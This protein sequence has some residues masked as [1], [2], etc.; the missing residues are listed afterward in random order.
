M[1]KKTGVGFL[2]GLVFVLLTAS[3]AFS[4]GYVGG[5]LGVS[6]PHDVSNLRGS[7]A[8]GSGGVSSFT[9]DSSVAGEFR[10]GYFF[11]SI[12]WLGAEFNFSISEPDVD[13][14]V[15]ITITSSPGGLL[16]GLSTGDFIGVVDVDHYSTMGF[17]LMLSSERANKTYNG[18]GAFGGLGF[19]VNVLDIHRVE[20]LNT[21]RVKQS[22]VD[23][24]SITDI[25]FLMSVGLDY[26]ITENVK[27]YGAYKYKNTDFT[28]KAFDDSL[29]YKFNVEE[30]ALTFGAT[31][32]LGSSSFL[33]S[34]AESVHYY[35]TCDPCVTR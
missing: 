1:T 26:K 23:G 17:L 9:P 30:S 5:G 34:M 7:A 35:L 12:P 28:S 8:A 13:D 11:K 4:E 27:A 24:K 20:V 16:N 32:S 29:D 22:D 14:T 6:I 19:G 25:G 2:L 15:N 18:F 3:S 33:E 10:M 31:Y 21:N